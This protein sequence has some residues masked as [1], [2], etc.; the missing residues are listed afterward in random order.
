M[1]AIHARH[2]IH[3]TLSHEVPPVVSR[4]N[5]MDAIIRTFEMEKETKKTVKYQELPDAGQ[6]EICGSLYVQK[7]AAGQPPPKLLQVRIDVAK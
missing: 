1:T 5:D 6:P 4:R 3:H 2:S 7:W